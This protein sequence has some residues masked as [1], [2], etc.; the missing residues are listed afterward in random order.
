[1]THLDGTTGDPHRKPAVGARDVETE[2]EGSPSDTSR[3]GHYPGAP[4]DPKQQLRQ[5]S[6]IGL[7]CRSRQDQ[8]P[9]ELI[10]LRSFLFY[11]ATNARNL[12]YQRE[13]SFG[14]TQRMRVGISNNFFDV[15]Q[16]QIGN[17][18]LRVHLMRLDCDRALRLK[19]NQGF[20]FC[21]L[22]PLDIMGILLLI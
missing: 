7:R 16:H 14:A 2:A 8:R 19:M 22:A 18:G 9:C 20:G 21:S 3:P 15:I 12:P 6:Y 4:S 1:M 11:A 5:K 13:A 10:H 17:P